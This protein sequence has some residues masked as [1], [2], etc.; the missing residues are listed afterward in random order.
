MFTID[1]SLK[2]SQLYAGC[3]ITEVGGRLTLATD[4]Q[5]ASNIVGRNVAQMLEEN[6]DHTEVTI[7]GPMAVWS[8]LVVFHWVVHRFGKVWYDDGRSGPILIA[9]H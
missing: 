3:K 1:L 2:N 4:S 7:T 8:Y 9:Q 6:E 5:E